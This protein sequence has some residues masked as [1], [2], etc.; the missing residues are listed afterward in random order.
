MVYIQRLPFILTSTITII[1]GLV[2]Y[3]SGVSA[4][5]TFIKMIISITAFYLVGL[6]IRNSIF[7][8]KKQVDEKKKQEELES[9]K[10]AEEELENKDNTINE[11]ED[12]KA[13]L[14]AIKNDNGVNSDEFTPLKASKVIRESYLK[15][16]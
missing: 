14:E 6:Y 1:I 15:T 3:I 13:D 11:K 4:R 16:E 9:Q 7:E 2:C 12:M 8:I 5:D 10:K